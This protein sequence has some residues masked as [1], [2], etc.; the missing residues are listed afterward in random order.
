VVQQD[1]LIA[2]LAKVGGLVAAYLF[3]SHAR[4]TAR[5]GSDLDVALWLDHVP[6]TLDDLQLDLAAD[7]ERDLGVPV[8]VVILNAAPS[9][10]VHRVLRDGSILVEHD[11][12]ARI[13]LEVRARNDYFDLLPIRNAYR[14][15]RRAAPP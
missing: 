14:Y 15:G 12:S 4:G 1:L 9:D 2:R 11:R 10:L 5:S 3:G 13:R 8:D 6:A 7:L